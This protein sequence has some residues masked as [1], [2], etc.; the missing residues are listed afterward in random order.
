MKYLNLHFF[1]GMQDIESK[2]KIIKLMYTM[3]ATKLNLPNVIHI[4][5]QLM[6]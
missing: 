2:R 5:N 1:F 6:Q 4:V 3:V